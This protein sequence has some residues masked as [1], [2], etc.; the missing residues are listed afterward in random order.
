M[1]KLLGSIKNRITFFLGLSIVVVII[2]CMFISAYA[3]NSNITENIEDYLKMEADTKAEIINSWLEKQAITVENMKTAITILDNTGAGVEEIQEYLSDCL[4]DNENALM[5]YMCY[6]NQDKAFMAGGETLDLVVTEREWWK[7]AVEK[8]ELIYTSP[9]QDAATGGMVISI[10]SPFKLKGVQCVVLADFNLD[11]LVDMVNNIDES[12][13]IQ[14]F[15]LTE[16]GSVIVHDNEK[17]LPAEDNVVI[18]ADELG[19]DLSGGKNGR[20]KDYDGKDKF[21]HI[22]NIAATDWTLGIME[23]EAVLNKRVIENMIL[24]II[25][26]VVLMV[27]AAVMTGVIIKQSLKPMDNMKKFVVEKIIGEENKPRERNEVKEIQLL[28]DE[29]QNNFIDTIKHAQDISGKVD[30][31]MI[32]TNDKIITINKSIKDISVLIEEN[33]D[34]IELQ[35]EAISAINMTCNEVADAVEQLSEQAQNIAVKAGD[36]I[37][38]VNSAVPAII[39]GKRQAV[40]MTTDSC[41]KLENAISQVEVIHEITQISNAI[42]EIAEQTNLLALNASI[43][44]ARAGEAGKGFVV[45]ADEIK[46]LS[47]VTDKEIDKVNELASKILDSVKVLS[48]ESS[49]I[50]RFLNTD[51]LRNYDKLERLANDYKNDA[52][53]YEAVST[54]LGAS[55]E[56][57]NASIQNIVNTLTGIE[58][59]QKQLNTAID[60]ITDSLKGMT[61]AS[62]EVAE[63]TRSVLN[64][65]NKLNDTVSRFN[66]L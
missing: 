47:E 57:L 55:G 51:V 3:L 35:S 26:G 64:E 13:D 59:G 29:L 21:I 32:G 49:N 25:V 31:K 23:N 12:K 7:T 28:I 11:V 19:V 24:I 56:E 34:N 27:I 22:S 9:Y 15:L 30:T 37:T 41:L 50:I 5:Y 65:V 40:S 48:A 1:K 53:Y 17:Y 52:A 60:N 43:E 54:E 8:Q 44:A 20:I 4:S 42:R 10:A 62:S 58:S 63:D 46:S 38:R 45:V 14:G 33:C 61:G 36:I 18:L 39:A 16:D 2:V 6:E 66:V